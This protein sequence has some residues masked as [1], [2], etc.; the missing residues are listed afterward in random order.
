MHLSSFKWALLSTPILTLA[1]PIKYT[2]DTSSTDS[3]SLLVFQFASVLEQLESQFYSQALSQFTDGDFLD[4]GFSSASIPTQLFQTISQDEQSHLTFLN[5]AIAALGGSPLQCNFNFGSALSS[6]TDMVNTARVVENVGVAAYLGGAS[7]LTDPVITVEAGTIA[8]VEAR[9][10]TMLNLLSS[11]G[12]TIPVPFDVALSPSEVLAIA[13]GFI[14]GCQLP[15]PANPALTI[16]NSE[17]PTI[18]SQL[19]F[20][21]D[22][23]P[24]DTSSLFCQMLVGGSVTALVLPFQQCI[25]PPGINGPVALFI[26]SNNDPLL[27]NVVDRATNTLVAGPA[28]AFIDSASPEAVV[29]LVR[30]SSSGG[31]AVSTNTTVSSETASSI[32]AN[33][34]SSASGSDTS[35]PNLST[36]S[37]NGGNVT[38]IGWMNL[39][40]SS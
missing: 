29:N 33:G 13:G 25:V 9:H 16:T 27:N 39:P 2:R 28:M 21:F 17:T 35:G 12:S 31:V 8:T 11:T 1:G 4:A 14:S 10:Q 18:G 26:T 24:S 15:I 5:K 7:L 36:G 30:P 3:T 20:S 34:T 19:T 22:N 32:I 38:V 37:T 6:V 23:M 40:S